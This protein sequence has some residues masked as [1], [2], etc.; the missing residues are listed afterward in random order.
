MTF[1]FYVNSA[2]PERVDKTAFLSNSLQVDSGRIEPNQ[3]FE[4]PTVLVSFDSPPRYNYVKI[5]DFDRYYFVRDFQWVGDDVYRLSL[6]EDYLMSWKDEIKEVEA[7]ISRTTT[8]INPDVP[9]PT[10]L[11]LPPTAGNVVVL[12]M[13]VK[14]GYH[15]FAHDLDLDPSHHFVFTG[16]LPG[17]VV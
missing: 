2:E 10:F 8:P 9:D 1:V 6:V 3:S 7:V 11:T 5:V 16:V 17:G 4:T 12:Q 13:P 15:G 14:S